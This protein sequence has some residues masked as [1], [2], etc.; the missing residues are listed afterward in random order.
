[1][2]QFPFGVNLLP[3]DYGAYAQVIF[4]DGV[5]I[6]ETA[7]YRPGL[8]VAQL[9]NASIIVTHKCTIIRHAKSAV[10]LGVDI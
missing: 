3:L 6:V 8:I 4:G 2:T 10:K 5:R 1:M 7:G 9:K